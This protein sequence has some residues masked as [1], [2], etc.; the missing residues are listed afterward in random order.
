MENK[1][2]VGFSAIDIG[3][4]ISCKFGIATIA[5]TFTEEA[6]AIGETLEIVEKSDSEQ[7]F[8]IL[9]D[10]ASVL[11]GI[12]DTS[13]MNN[14]SHITQIKDK[15]ERLESGGKDILFYWIPGHCGID[16]N[17]RAD[18]EAKIVNYYYQWQNLKPSGKRE[19]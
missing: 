15:I 16:M 7:N 12:G 17:E 2:F 10:S 6:L 19:A 11:K 5:S 8:V 4:A 14:T 1:S 13:A 18:S 3:D 9:S